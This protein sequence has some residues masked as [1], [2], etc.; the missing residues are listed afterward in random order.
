M[1]I[2]IEPRLPTGTALG[3]PLYTCLSVLDLWAIGN[4]CG[5][6]KTGVSSLNCGCAI[7]SCPLVLT[8]TPKDKTT[9]RGGA[10][11]QNWEA[12]DNKQKGNEYIKNIQTNQGRN[13]QKSRIKDE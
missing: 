9:T 3:L 11:K 1:I 6:I 4:S 13:T 2:G 10:S 5:L 8:I 7:G 12:K